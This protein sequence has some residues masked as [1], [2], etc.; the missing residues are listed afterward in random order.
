MRIEYK[1][2]FHI[3]ES[4][5]VCIVCFSLMTLYL[6]SGWRRVNSPYSTEKMRNRFLQRRENGLKQRRRGKPRR[7]RDSSIHA[8][9]KMSSPMRSVSISIVN[10]K[11]SDSSPFLGLEIL[12]NK[13][14]DFWVWLELLVI[15]K[16]QILNSLILN[17]KAGLCL[18]IAIITYYS[19]SSLVKFC[20]RLKNKLIK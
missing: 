15:A 16:H 2:I 8:I 9:S 5:A 19:R 6:L 14:R 3:K 7:G 20:D 1:I 13:T 10:H 18:L 4:S 11:W 12:A 17:E